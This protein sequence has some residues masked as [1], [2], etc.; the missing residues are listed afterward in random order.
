VIL[1][2]RGFCKNVYIKDNTERH[3]NILSCTSSIQANQISGGRSIAFNL[4][5]YSSFK[6]AQIIMYLI[7]N[8]ITHQYN[9]LL[10]EDDVS[11]LLSSFADSRRELE[12]P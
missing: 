9:S 6:I 5:A 8:W 7:E 10:Q 12:E 4:K 1:D 11:I 2:S 3:A